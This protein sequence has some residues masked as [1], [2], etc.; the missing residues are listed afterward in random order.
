MFRNSRLTCS[1]I[2][3]GSTINTLR[4]RLK[5]F[6]SFT[7]FSSSKL[8]PLDC[9]NTYWADIRFP[10]YHFSSIRP[11]IWQVLDTS[12]KKMNEQLSALNKLASWR[13]E[14]THAKLNFSYTAKVGGGLICRKRASFGLILSNHYILKAF[15]FQ[16]KLFFPPVKFLNNSSASYFHILKF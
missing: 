3:K 8:F 5:A 15:P 11:S 13:Q 1:G 16:Q 10:Y 7:V 14:I 4:V 6:C 2:K 12:W 9:S